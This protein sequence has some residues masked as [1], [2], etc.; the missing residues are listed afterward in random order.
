MEESERIVFVVCG[1]DTNPEY[2]NLCVRPYSSLTELLDR[3]S[4]LLELLHD[5]KR[6]K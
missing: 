6:Q 4:F 3:N 2:M 5:T 1:H